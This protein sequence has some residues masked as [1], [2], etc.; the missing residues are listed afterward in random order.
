M[1]VM[2]VDPDGD[3][4]LYKVSGKFLTDENG[5]ITNYYDGYAT[6][7]PLAKIK[8]NLYVDK[9][10]AISSNLTVWGKMILPSWGSLRARI[11]DAYKDAINKGADAGYQQ[12]LAEYVGTLVQPLV[13]ATNAYEC[14]EAVIEVHDCE[15]NSYHRLVWVNSGH[16]MN[17]KDDRATF[18]P[19]NKYYYRFDGSVL[20]TQRYNQAGSLQ[21]AAVGTNFCVALPSPGGVYYFVGKDQRGAA[22]LDVKI[23]FDLS[24]DSKPLHVDVGTWNFV[25]MGES[26]GADGE[27]ET[28]Y[29]SVK[30]TERTETVIRTETYTWYEEYWDD[31]L[32]EWVVDYDNPITE[33]YEWY[34]EYTNNMI[35]EIEPYTCVEFHFKQVGPKAM[36]V[37]VQELYKTNPV[38]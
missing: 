36:K 26:V 5:I 35:F 14:G 18:F 13:A 12:T 11:G 4:H 32:G 17:A 9:H 21:H 23:L 3:S 15:S 6:T 2:S 7:D 25:D 37:D 19:R 29:S 22:H 27:W 8:G 28:I 24:G 33:T 20:R 16:A 30:P 10:V 34:D 1:N 38:R 31:E